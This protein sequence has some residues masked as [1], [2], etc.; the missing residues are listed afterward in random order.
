MKLRE[1]KS[2]LESNR[3]KQ[4]LLML[5][6]ETAVPESFHVTEVGLVD[7]NFIDCGGKI[8]SQQTCQIQ[9]WVGDD[10]DHRIQAGKLAD[11][12]QLAKKVVPN[13]DIDLEIEY[14]D[15]VI[16]QYTIADCEL[17]DQAVTLRLAS[18]H[19]DCLAKEICLLPVADSSCDGATGCC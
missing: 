15:E 4:F 7:K 8:H 3:G 6:N 13:D 5:P 2:L 1:L 12:I 11:I 14:E 16:S 17:T 9:A 10:T 18:K 19:T